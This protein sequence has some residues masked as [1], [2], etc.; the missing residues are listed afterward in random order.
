MIFYSPERWLSIHSCGYHHL[1]LCPFL[2]SERD[3]SVHLWD[4]IHLCLSPR[5]PTCASL[6]VARQSPH[7]V[8][9]WSPL[10]SCPSH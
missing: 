7:L 8:P 3:G 9:F 6:Q 10:P 4:L 1:R 5:G 2:H